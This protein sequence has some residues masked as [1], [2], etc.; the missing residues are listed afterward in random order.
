MTTVS[1]FSRPE[2][3]ILFL[4]I[5]LKHF[6]VVHW[7]ETKISEVFCEKPFQE[8]FL[9]I[10]QYLGHLLDLWKRKGSILYYNDSLIIY[11]NEI[12]LEELLKME[13]D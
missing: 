5:D 12:D 7:E 1:V 6:S 3:E 2:Q 13:L 8:I 10:A 11:S 4:W 9:R